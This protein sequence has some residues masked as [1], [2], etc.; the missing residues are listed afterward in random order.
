M[1]KHCCPRVGLFGANLLWLNQFGKD[2]ARRTCVLRSSGRL[3]VFFGAGF[4]YLR[5][6]FRCT[7]IHTALI[8]TSEVTYYFSSSDEC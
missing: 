4:S 3:L 7:P 1:K 8:F 6:I 5:N 2:P